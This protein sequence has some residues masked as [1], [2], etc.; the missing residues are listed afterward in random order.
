MMSKKTLKFSC[1]L[2][3]FRKF[4][5]KQNPNHNAHRTLNLNAD[6]VFCCQISV[7][8]FMSN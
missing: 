7:F 6:I 4:I 8:K 2:N 1:Q 3:D 5:K